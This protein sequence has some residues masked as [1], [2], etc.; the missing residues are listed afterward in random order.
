MLCAIGAAVCLIVIV[1]HFRGL[2]ISMARFR[3]AQ[4]SFAHSMPRL[5]R[6]PAGVGRPARCHWPPGQGWTENRC[7][8]SSLRLTTSLNYTSSATVSMTRSDSAC[9]HP[10]VT[11]KTGVLAKW[12]GS[13]GSPV[14]WSFSEQVRRSGQYA[15]SL[16]LLWAFGL[17]NPT[18]RRA[19]LT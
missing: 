17:A 8:G 1:D 7:L 9:S 10:V 15:I 2:V 3:P 5:H 18:W 4:R 16:S 13:S 12:V 11:I 6:D 19:P 14:R